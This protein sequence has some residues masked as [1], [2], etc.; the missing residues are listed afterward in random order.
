MVA[1]LRVRRH[2]DVGVNI[3]PVI[4]IAGRPYI[5]LNTV[6]RVQLNARRPGAMLL[7]QRLATIS[8]VDG[9]EDA[10][11]GMILCGSRVVRG[12]RKSCAFCANRTIV[13][14]DG[15]RCIRQLCDASLVGG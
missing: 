8:L 11:G 2:G 15:D 13:Q 3:P 1:R 9:N 12:P 4:S 5:R 7:A 10:Y 6:T 14:C